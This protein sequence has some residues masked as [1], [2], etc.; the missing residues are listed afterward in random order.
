MSDE[1]YN[2]ISDNH[3]CEAPKRTEHLLVTLAG[4]T[5]DSGFYRDEAGYQWL[6]LTFTD[7]TSVSFVGE[8]GEPTEMFEGDQAG[9]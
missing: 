5:I 9:M 6:V 3:A 2:A 1:V 4:K 8:Y 7:G